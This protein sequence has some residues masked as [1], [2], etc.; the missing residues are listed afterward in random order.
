VPGLAGPEVVVEQA[1]EQRVRVAAAAG[2]LVLEQRVLLMRP[3]AQPDVEVEAD[4]RDDD[5]LA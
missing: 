4:E 2:A 3:E 1:I 5:D